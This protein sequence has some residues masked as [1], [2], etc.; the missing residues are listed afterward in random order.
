[1]EP[2]RKKLS[3]QKSKHCTVYYYKL[4]YLEPVLLKVMAL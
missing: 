1:M 4:W 2:T 3:E